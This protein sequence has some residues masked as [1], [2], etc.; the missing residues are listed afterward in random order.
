MDARH[1]RRV[2]HRHAPAR[3]ARRGRRRR[4]ERAARGRRRLPPARSFAHSSTATTSRRA[5]ISRRSRSAGRTR[6][7][8]CSRSGTCGRTASSAPTTGASSSPQRA[9]AAGN[10]GA[11][12]RDAAE[13]RGVPRGAA[14]GRPARPLDCVPVVAGADALIVSARGGGVRVRALR[15][16]HNADGHD[17]DGL[18]TGL[19][20]LAERLWDE[21]GAAR[22]DRRRLGLRRLP[23]DGADPARRPRL[24]RAARPRSRRS[25]RARSPST[26][27]AASSRPGRRA[28]PAACTASSRSSSS[29]AAAPA[30]AR[31]RARASASRAATAW[32]PT[33]TARARTPSCWRRRERRRGQPL[34]RCGWQGTPR[35]LWCPACGADRV[36]QVAVAARARSRRRRPCAASRAA[37]TRPS[38]SRASTLEGGGTLIARLAGRRSGARVRLTDDGGAPVATPAEGGDVSTTQSAGTRR[39]QHDRAQAVR[40]GVAERRRVRAARGAPGARGRDQRRHRVRARRGRRARGLPGVAKVSFQTAASRRRA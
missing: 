10:P 22:R 24:R 27:P 11:V 28:R 36:E 34:R 7:S 30:S 17:G 31:S 16:A 12:Y 32:S 8:R 40:A 26:R 6:S 20:A 2:R 38:R 21:A 39:G 13:R 9:W 18:E 15:A 33:A 19:R 35:R 4:L 14:R 25:R 37:S 3:A 23:G 1:G 5:S 29:C